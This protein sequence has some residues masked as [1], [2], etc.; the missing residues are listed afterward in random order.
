VAVPSRALASSW[1]SSSD[2]AGEKSCN[3]A[4]DF[5]TADTAR[6]KEP[7]WCWAACIQTIF[8][9]HGYKVAQDRI[10][11]KIFADKADRC[12]N[13]P[14]ILSAINGEWTED[15]GRRFH[16]EGVLL[17]DRVDSIVQPDAV[18]RAAAELENGNPLI[19]ATG[20]HTVVLTAMAYRLTTTGAITVDSLTVRD[21]WPYVVNS[22]TLPVSEIAR[23]GFLC[24][25]HTKD[26]GDAPLSNSAVADLR[27]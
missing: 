21:P 3:A 18:S 8:A 13:G 23:S 27:G 10:V 6:Q 12:A 5:G 16:A 22:H 7:H 2:R 15:S 17:W 1:C 9:A 25:I 11:Q 26:L 20:G 19:F 24:G 14:Q 4:F